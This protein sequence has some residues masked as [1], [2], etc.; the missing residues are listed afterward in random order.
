[1]SALIGMRVRPWATWVA[2]S[3]GGQLLGLLI[4]IGAFALADSWSASGPTSPLVALAGQLILVSP[5]VAFGVGAVPQALLLR[6]RW[7]PAW[8]L[9][10]ISAWT[11]VG[12]LSGLVFIGYLFYDIT[13]P[14]G[15]NDVLAW[16]A[17]ITACVALVVT[18]LQAAVLWG[19]VTVPRLLLF[20]PLTT[21]GWIVGWSYSIASHLG[22]GVGM[23]SFLA[24]LVV[25]LLYAVPLATIAAASGLVLAGPLATG[26][27]RLSDRTELRRRWV[28]GSV[29]VLT[30]LALAAVVFAMVLLTFVRA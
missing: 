8:G 1:M 18:L 29:F 12:A 14:P 25:D 28:L 22:M 10:R 20:V 2:V 16:Y 11:I 30:L 19:P 27:R 6:R 26:P 17:P 15:W 7:A 21:L 13:S 24:V 4:L 9:G 3:V 23:N 5:F